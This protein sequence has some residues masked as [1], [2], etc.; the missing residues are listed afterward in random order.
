MLP[1][2]I[3]LSAG[4]V[5]V[6]IAFVYAGIRKLRDRVGARIAVLE[7]RLV[8]ARATGLVASALGICEVSVGAGLIAGLP[9]ATLGGIALLA[10]FSPAAVSALARGLDID[11]HCFGDGEK[12][13]A[14][15]LVRNAG[16]VTVLGTAHFLRPPP[17]SS[18][19]PQLLTAPLPYVLSVGITAAAIV[20]VG[21]AIRLS[22][23]TAAARR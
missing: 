1:L 9:L 14:A 18:L 12:L 13:S 6:G 23:G 3:A 4:Q 7:Y 22:R 8:P 2:E 21:S 20:A 16:L 17:S 11:C 10:L 19:A 5:L 15:T